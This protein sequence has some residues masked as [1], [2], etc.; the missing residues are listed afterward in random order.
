MKHI[1]LN[2]SAGIG[3][4][5]TDIFDLLVDDQKR[6]YESLIN[7]EEVIILSESDP[8]PDRLGRMLVTVKWEES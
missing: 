7:N 5:H 8:T 6:K 2:K 4:K 1:D 3:R